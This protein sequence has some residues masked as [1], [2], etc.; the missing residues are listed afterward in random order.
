MSSLSALNSSQ[1]TELYLLAADILLAV[2]ALVVAFVVIGLLLTL[3]GKP[4][5]WSWVRNP[6]FR[7]VHL[8][9]IGIVVIQAWLGVIC[10]LTIW[11]MALRERAGDAVY[12][13]SFI[14]HWLSQVLYY[15]L[16]G[17]VFI[18]SYTLF[19]ALVLASWIWVRPRPLRSPK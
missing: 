19:G 18:V 13:G 2:H 15:Q 8:I 6:W 14:S 3:L 11:E 17:W 1:P 4:C 5:K 16:P 7:W 10:P 9:T 12:A